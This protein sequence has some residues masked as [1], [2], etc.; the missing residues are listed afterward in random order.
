MDRKLKMGMVGGGRG[1]FI[2]GVHRMAAMLDGKVELVCGAFS[3]DP[4][5]SKDSG[6]DL[7][8]PADRVYGSFQEMFQKE[9]KLPAGTR[10]DFVSVVTPNNVH[11]PACKAAIEHGFS[12][13]CDKP[14]AYSLAEAKELEALVRKTGVVFALTHNYTGYPLV[15]EA[16][17]MVRSGEIGKVRKVVVEYPQ[18]WL[19]TLIEATGQKQASWRTDPRRAGPSS[20]IGDIG[21]HCENLAEYVTGLRITEVCADFTTFVAGR[22]LEDDAN[23]LLRLEGGAK[24]LLFASQISAGEENHIK[25]R[26]YGEKA[27][28]HW[29]QEEPNT[30][31]IGW[32]DKPW[33]VKRVGGGYSFL[34]KEALR[35]T[36]LPSGHVEGYLEAFAN[37]YRN[38]A[39][40]LA[41]KL[42]GEK[43]TAEQL[44]F[45]TVQDGVRG[46]AFIETTVA[47][48]KSDAKWTR[49]LG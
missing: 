36:R 47:S 34:S 24:G 29:D 30:L 2:G 5:R 43:P 33:E 26:V 9:Q 28:L 21:S 32:A 46:M 45:P 25:I 39:D 16:R 37:I 23:V 8:L 40:T 22:K 41:C 44:D 14:L 42:S 12:V 3:S 6:K 1:A 31:L 11:F 48:A 27:G 17:K 13:V 7:F 35:A 49:M 20:C 18:G 19:N 15:K 4:Q 38:F 10:M